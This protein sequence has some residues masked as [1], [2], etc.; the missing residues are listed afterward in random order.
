MTKRIKKILIGSLLIA[1]SISLYS[2]SKNKDFEIVKNLDI[3]MTLFKELNL[4]YVD[5]TDPGELVKTSIDAMLNS[6][7]PYTT[8]IPE[9]DIEDYRFMTTGQYG[10]V[11][12]I[13][14]KIDGKIV[15]V[16]PYQ[17]EPIDSAGLKAGDII[18]SINDEST[19]GKS[20]GDI[21]KILKGQPN[22][23]VHLVIERPGSQGLIK[24]TV[25]RKK[26]T[27]NSVPYAGV[28]DNDIGYIKLSSFTHNSSKEVEKAFKDL[29]RDN[30]IKAIIL[31]LRSNPGGLLI[32]AVNVVNI[33]VNNGEHIVSTKGR[34]PQWNKDFNTMSSP[35]D[36]VIPLVVMVNRSSASA[37]EIVAG[38]V[39]DLDRGI[40]IGQRTFGKGLVQT[41]RSLS[42]NAKLKV[43]TAK[44]YIPSGRCIQAL[45]YSHRNPD[46]SVGRVP[47]SLISEFETRNGRKVYDGGG[48]IPDIKMEEDDPGFIVKELMKEN[49][50]FNF[51]THYIIDF[52]NISKPDKYEL[53]DTVFT[54]FVDYLEHFDFDYETRREKMFQ[55]LVKVAKKEKY[56]NLAKEEFDELAR[57]LQHD[58]N[59]DLFLFREEI[60]ELL[61]EEIVSRFF[62]QKGRVQEAL[63]NDNEVDTSIVVLRDSS[64]Y[65]QIL[66]IM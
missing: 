61:E 25:Y 10:G 19:E 1:I 51:V 14:Q 15:I 42:Y 48:I 55:E 41:T 53:P 46:G 4:F 36:T 34:G 32:E 23:K 56:Y 64:R 8:Y 9:S 27:I 24:R 63:E 49:C 44:Y 65:N 62:Y 40:V 38:A 59:K 16:E 58:K 43:T 35:L 31:D 12:A 11:G 37:S 7:D 2:F 39:Q 50:I 57:K 18:L 54:H 47:D 13:I 60:E 30:N 45:D 33:F 21:S 66:Q 5:E 17:D 20:T 52:T 22:T 29:K 28:I 3:Y 26:I 6:L